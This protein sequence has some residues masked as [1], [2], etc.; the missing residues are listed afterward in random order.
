M[1]FNV[2]GDITE[3]L[4]DDVTD[5]F[6]LGDP[7]VAIPDDSDEEG[8]GVLHLAEA[9]FHHLAGLALLIGDAP[10][11]VDLRQGHV[12][13][14]GH[15]PQSGKGPP[16]QFGPLVLHVLEG[17]GN[18]DADGTGINERRFC[19][20]TT[21]ESRGCILPRPGRRSERPYHRHPRAD[22]R[23]GRDPHG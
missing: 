17:G 12:P 13:L 5:I 2:L 1:A 4:L 19:C 18:E 11:E 8:D 16:N 15:F 6:G 14:G 21:E 10:A 7:T 22:H 9:Y 3:P 23:N 20:H